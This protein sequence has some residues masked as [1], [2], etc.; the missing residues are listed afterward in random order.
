[1]DGKNSLKQVLKQVPNED[2]DEDSVLWNSLQSSELPTS[3]SIV[4]YCYLTRVHIKSEVDLFNND[5]KDN[6]PCVGRWKNMKDDKTKWM[7]RV[8][9][10]SEIFMAT[11]CR[12]V[13]ATKVEIAQ[14]RPMSHDKHYRKCG[15][16]NNKTW[17]KQHGDSLAAWQASKKAKVLP[18]TGSNLQNDENFK[19]TVSAPIFTAE[20][21]T[22]TPESTTQ[23]QIPLAD[24]ANSLDIILSNNVFLHDTLHYKTICEEV[25]DEEDII[26][27][28]GVQWHERD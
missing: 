9:D 15:M 8:F 21:C 17:Q 2:H 16:G 14:K 18:A 25:E 26:A 5:D 1:M 12:A 6:N 13:N 3:Q 4:D 28:C 22:D 20:D 7:W 11:W 27:I 19:N 10:K 23:V 24:T